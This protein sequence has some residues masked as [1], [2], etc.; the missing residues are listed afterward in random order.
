MNCGVYITTFALCAMYGETLPSTIDCR[1]LRHVFATILAIKHGQKNSAPD[2]VIDLGSDEQPG[3]MARPHDM[4]AYPALLESK[5]GPLS[6]RIT[7]LQTFR[8]IIARI[9]DDMARNDTSTALTELARLVRKFRSEL[10]QMDG[11]MKQT[12]NIVAEADARISTSLQRLDEGVRSL[13]Q[14][15]VDAIDAIR[16]QAASIMER[17]DQFP[18]AHL[19]ISIPRRKRGMLGCHQADQACEQCRGGLSHLVG[20]QGGIHQFPS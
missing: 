14:R 10:E 17:C 9:Q 2:A 7:T 19:C 13:V 4:F 15:S 3:S 12:K 8:Y 16:Q 1:I 11:Q 5:E 6:T 20:G 18:Q